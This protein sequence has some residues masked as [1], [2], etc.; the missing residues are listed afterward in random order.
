MT[1]IGSLLGPEAVSAAVRL[2]GESGMSVRVQP[3]PWHLGPES[4]DVRDAWIDGWIGA[5]REQDPGLDG[6][7]DAYR[8]RRRSQAVGG[9]LRAVVHH[10]DLLA[11]PS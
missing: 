4:A 5:A 3:S 10:V 6:R 11:W 2:L 9:Q 7:A 1:S 8:G